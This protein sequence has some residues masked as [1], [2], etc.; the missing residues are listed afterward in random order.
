MRAAW[1]RPCRTPIAVGGFPNAREK[2]P[3]RRETRCK[4]ILWRTYARNED[5]RLLGM[6]VGA[7]G[8]T[9]SLVGLRSRALRGWRHSGRSRNWQ[10]WSARDPPIRRPSHSRLRNNSGRAPLSNGFCRPPPSSGRQALFSSSQLLAPPRRGFFPP[11]PF[12]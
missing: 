3:Y 5:D 7:P 9:S 12:A 1:N 11:W 10:L 6:R 8:K 4:D 2:H